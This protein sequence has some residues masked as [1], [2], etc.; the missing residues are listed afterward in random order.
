MYIDFM[1]FAA[2]AMA[3][4]VIILYRILSSDMKYQKNGLKQLVILA[5]FHNAI[6]IFWGLTYYNRIGMGT[7]GLYIST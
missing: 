1:M 3:T 6:D 4:D 5:L 2:I 7:V